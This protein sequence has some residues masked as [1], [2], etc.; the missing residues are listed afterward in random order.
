MGSRN[1]SASGAGFGETGG[2]AK[3]QPEP[4]WYID[5][6]ATTTWP[7]GVIA[8]WKLWRSHQAPAEMRSVALEYLTLTVT[9][10]KERGMIDWTWRP[11]RCTWPAVKGGE[12]SASRMPGYDVIAEVARHICDELDRRYP[13]GTP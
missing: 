5:K 3:H 7:S 8:T 9:V 11:A 10:E 2:P 4:A 6:R 1:C 13:P 12:A